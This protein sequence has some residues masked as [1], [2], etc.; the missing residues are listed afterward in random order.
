MTCWLCQSTGSL[1]CLLSM[2]PPV[3]CPFLRRHPLGKQHN[4]QQST[5]LRIVSKVGV[6]LFWMVWTGKDHAQTSDMASDLH[7]LHARHYANSTT[8]IISFNSHKDILRCIVTSQFCIWGPRPRAD[9]SFAWCHKAIM[10]QNQELKKGLCVSIDHSLTPASCCRE[11]HVK[12][13]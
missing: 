5:L 12:I 6:K 10:W 13:F 3:S 2:S 9:K 1:F 7:L 8:G 4:K 11:P